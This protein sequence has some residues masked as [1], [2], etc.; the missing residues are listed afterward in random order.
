MRLFHNG[1]QVLS[2]VE[3]DF[4]PLDPDMESSY[5]V[6]PE[7]GA[8]GGCFEFGIALKDSDDHAVIGGIPHSMLD[9]EPLSMAAEWVSAGWEPVGQVVLPSVAAAR[10][11]IA[12]GF[13]V[14]ASFG[15][16]LPPVDSLE[17]DRAQIVASRSAASA[18]PWKV[19]ERDG[20]ATSVETQWVWPEEDDFESHRYSRSMIGKTVCALGNRFVAGGR[21]VLKVRASVGGNSIVVGDGT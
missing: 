13:P 8:L 16:F 6:A 2:A 18:L 1:E 19:N 21:Y 15:T 10:A 7:E 4:I 11:A 12:S 3:L 17:A 9:E 5:V 20:N 14:Q